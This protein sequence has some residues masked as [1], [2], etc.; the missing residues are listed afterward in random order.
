M[1]HKAMAEGAFCG[2][3]HGKVAFPIETACERC[4]QG[5]RPAVPDTT[6]KPEA[7]GALLGNIA[8]VRPG[9]DS[10]SAGKGS[11]YTPAR[12]AHWSHRVR[13]RCSACHPALFVERAGANVI[14]ME[15]IGRGQSCGACHNGKV[16]F[17]SSMDTCDKCHSQGGAVAAT[18]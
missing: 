14:T 3:C 6:R 4:H 10:A 15:Q 11:F 1:T 17:A 18:K 13:Y 8:F 12:F 2:A 7:D 9:L 5:M 16:A